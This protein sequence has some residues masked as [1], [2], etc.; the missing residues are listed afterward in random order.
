MFKKIIFITFIVFLLMYV[1]C[2]ITE[3]GGPYAPGDV[4]YNKTFSHPILVSVN[5]ESP[6]SVRLYFSDIIK[7]EN[8]LNYSNYTISPSLQIKNIKIEQ[9]RP[10]TIVLLTTST[11][12]S[13]QVYTITINNMSNYNGLEISSSRKSLS[14]PGYST[15]RKI[16]INEVV[17]NPQNNSGVPLDTSNDG[18]SDAWAN[19]FIELYNR[20]SVDINLKGWKIGIETAYGSS[21]KH[22]FLEDKII[23]AK[24]FLTVWGGGSPKGF[25]SYYDVCTNQHSKYPGFDMKKTSEGDS[26]T[27]EGSKITLYDSAGNVVDVL[28]YGTQFGTQTAIGYGYGITYTENGAII[29]Y[30]DGTRGTF[31]LIFNRYNYTPNASNPSPF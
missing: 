8:I 15:N 20:T 21:I 1:S 30:P 27:D 23:P 11:Q 29:R 7:K 17:V 16:V 10:Y 22:T 28:G 14:F 31:L 5:E 12:S 18:G 6:T 4:S 3:N 13:T 2:S 9:S 19:Q 24:G 25:G 26:Y